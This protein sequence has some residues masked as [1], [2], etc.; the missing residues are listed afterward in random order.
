MTEIAQ[1]LLN[2]A[3]VSMNYADIMRCYM[4]VMVAIIRNMVKLGGIVMRLIKI[5]QQK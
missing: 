2:V 3:L 5:V 4:I 1:R